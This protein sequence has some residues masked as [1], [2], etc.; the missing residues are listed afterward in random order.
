MDQVIDWNT[1]SFLT[2]GLGFLAMAALW[3]ALIWI[4]SKDRD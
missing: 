3:G 2:L 1:R 4:L